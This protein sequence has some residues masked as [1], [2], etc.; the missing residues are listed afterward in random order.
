MDESEEEAQ[1]RKSMRCIWVSGKKAMTES[2]A[3]QQ[4]VSEA[5]LLL[6]QDLAFLGVEW[7]PNSLVSETRTNSSNEST[8]SSLQSPSEGS[9]D[10]RNEPLRKLANGHHIPADQNL[11]SHN[12]QTQSNTNPKPSDANA[13][14]TTNT[15]QQSTALHKVLK[16]INSKDKISQDCCKTN[17]ISSAFLAHCIHS[18]DNSHSAQPLSKRRRTEDDCIKV[19]SEAKVTEAEKTCPGTDTEVHQASSA[20]LNDSHPELNNGKTPRRSTT[21]HNKW[22]PQKSWLSSIPFHVGEIPALSSQPRFLSCGEKTC[23]GDIR[24]T[25]QCKNETQKKV[26]SEEE[27]KKGKYTDC[28]KESKTNEILHGPCPSTS[29][30]FLASS[31]MK[32]RVA[33]EVILISGEKCNSPDLYTGELEEF[34]DSFL[35]DTQTE[36][37]LLLDDKL[38][39]TNSKTLVEHGFKTTHS[40]VGTDQH[41]ENTTLVSDI[42][43]KYNK[44]PNDGASLVSDKIP[45]KLPSIQARSMYNISLTDS[46]MENLLNFTNQ[47]TES[48]EHHMNLN[49][50]PQSQ[51][52]NSDTMTKEIHEGTV[53]NSLN[54][55]SSFLFDSLYDSFI[56]E[57]M[58]D[59]AEFAEEP[60]IDKS[61]HAN[62]SSC[63]PIV[64]IN[65][66]NKMVKEVEDQEAVQWGE[67]SFNL[68]EWGDSLLIGE[69]FL[70]KRNSGFKVCAGPKDSSS[71]TEKPC[72]TDDV[73]SEMHTSQNNAP[74]S[75]SATDSSF[76]PSPG[77]QDIFDKW[78]D[79]F[80][81]FCDPPGQ[82]DENVTQQSEHASQKGSLS[83][84][85]VVK[86][87]S[88]HHDLIPPTQVCEPVT[89][90][91]KMTTSAVQSPRNHTHM[92]SGFNSPNSGHKNNEHIKAVPQLE[93]PLTD[94]GFSLQLSQDASVSGSNLTSPESFSIIDV[95]SDERLF[96]TFVK[97]WKTKKRFSLA[98]AC[99][100]NNGT[101]QPESVIGSKFKKG[102]L[103]VYVVTVFKFSTQ[104]VIA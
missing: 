3:A 54:R 81:T 22:M 88:V 52:D 63:D 87:N 2:E 75:G 71:E 53:N 17:E 1:E 96:E 31:N 60:K 68:S 83:D 13:E 7:N 26:G 38:P 39:Y 78:S 36:R 24:N 44:D 102:N 12:A 15:E 48:C 42:K 58:D 33:S 65:E 97:E 104:K 6:Q 25:H 14:N 5:R 45:N 9:P 82:T 61:V 11:P 62:T 79:H 86:V 72:Y 100:R 76:H 21:L 80:P 56:L 74:H 59:E 95:A 46:Q 99:E 73:V 16:S 19:D 32:A 10:E 28:Y 101:A 90:R 23:T 18:S 93:S 92:E 51:T 98:V 66:G 91:V 103:Y 89:P 43:Q 49:S 4:I 37:M 77:M 67:S 64:A 8:G 20:S 84:L 70:E 35:L 57:A 94:E 50:K 55:S 30:G 69:H 34:G 29:V 41:S 27:S 85:H 47:T 40:H